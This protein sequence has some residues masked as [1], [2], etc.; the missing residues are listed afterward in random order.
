MPT[1]TDPQ[2]LSGYF[3]YPTVANHQVIFVSEDDLWSVPLSG[4]MARRLTAA[5][6]TATK[7]RL[8]PDGAWCAFTGREEGDAEIYLMPAEGGR[9]TPLNL[10]RSHHHSSRLG[11]GWS[12]GHRQQ[13]QKTL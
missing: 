13:R 2:N 4:G 6:G 12:Y 7:P 11:S 1:I 9:G 5:W 8:S 3:R 10:F